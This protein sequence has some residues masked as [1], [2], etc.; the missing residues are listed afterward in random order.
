MYMRVAIAIHHKWYVDNAAETMRRIKETYDLLSQGWFTDATPTLFNAGSMRQQLASCFLM[1]IGDDM[2]AIGECIKNCLVTSKY[3]GGIGI[4]MTN[5]RVDGAYIRSTQGKAS[6]LRL[7]RLFDEVARYA[8]QSGKRAG[9][10]AVYI[11]PW[12]GDVFFFLDLK[13]NTGA[14]TER[15]RDLFL[16]LMVNDIFMKRVES[17]GVW[18]LMCPSICLDLL[19]KYG[20][21]FTNIYERYEAQGKYLR[22]IRARDLWFKIMETQIESGVPYIVFK[23]AVNYKSNQI[24][25]GVI[26]GSNLCVSG[27][28]YILTSTGYH[29]IKRLRN[30]KVSVWNTEIFSEVTIKKTGSGQKLMRIEFSNGSILKCT[31]YHK[32]CLVDRI[33]PASDL[34]VGDKLMA[35]LYPIIREGLTDFTDAYTHGFFSVEGSYLNYQTPIIDL[36]PDKCHLVTHLHYVS[37]ALLT[38]GDNREGEGRGILR[39]CLP[40]DL[41][42]KHVVPTNYHL[43]IKMRWLAGL[44][45]GCGTIIPGDNTPVMLMSTNCKFLNNVKYL[46]HTVGCDTK[47]KLLVNDR[48][49]E[50]R[51]Q[52]YQIKPKYQLYVGV[53]SIL[54][55]LQLG[56]K[57]HHLRLRV[58]NPEVEI[59]FPITVTGI[60][61][62]TKTEDTY[63]FTEPTKN[64]GIF[65]GVATMNC[66]EIVEVSTPTEYAV[67]NLASICLPKFVTRDP[68]NGRPAFDHQKLYQITRTITCNLNN[69]IDI[70]F[71]PVSST[72]VSNLKH[73]PIGIGVQGL[74]DV[75][76]ACKIAFDSDLAKQLNKEIF[77]TIYFGAMTESMELAK[78]TDHTLPLMVALCLRV[79]SNS[80]CG[81]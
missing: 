34:V 65:N 43:N 70:N 9:S 17:D 40:Q 71:Y 60:S 21:E 14:E 11:E 13:K 42:A 26:N 10:I 55:L 7:L 72:K 81:A 37:G 56:L 67:C 64:T 1:G 80:I 33:S 68:I 29:K 30:K 5:I 15:T 52:T 41:N 19:N 38:D 23:D 4:N 58:A 36:Y 57:P 50:L 32:F 77:E 54:T 69:V 44:F 79:N 78:I 22:Q 59:H 28:T 51:G 3:A 18:S 31:P 62:L 49:D 73:R 47:V 35:S 53:D 12:H 2:E 16:A 39:L 27:N 6:G 8:D 75:F 20:D 61:K 74:A 48:I 24:N 45:D 25:I 46:L 66:A 63:C 76:I